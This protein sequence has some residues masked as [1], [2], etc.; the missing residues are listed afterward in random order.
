MIKKNIS[1]RFIAPMFF[2]IGGFF[3]LFFI[4]ALSVLPKLLLMSIIRS[5]KIPMI[6]RPVRRPV[7]ISGGVATFSVAQTAPNLG[8]GDK[9]SYGTN[10]VAYISAKQSQTVWNLITAK[11]ATPTA[12]SSAVVSS[13]T[14]AFSSLNRAIGSGKGRKIVLILIR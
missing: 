3:A 8:V 13:I 12:T 9:I 14:H 1:L 4:F 10:G 6:T 7:T 11:G 5:A 2:I